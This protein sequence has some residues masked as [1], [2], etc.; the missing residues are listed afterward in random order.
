MSRFHV[1]GVGGPGMSAIAIVLVQMGHV[2]SG[3]DIRESPVLDSLRALGVHINI[4]HDTSVV[5]GC[6]AVTA[7]SAI[8]SDNIELESA[9]QHKIKVLTR[10]Q[11]LADICSKK[12]SIGVA[13][14]HGKTTTAAM[15]MLMLMDADMHPSFIIGGDVADV[16]TGARWSTGPM[17]VVEADESDGTHRQLPLAGTILTNIDIDHLDHFGNLEGILAGFDGYLTG[18]SGPKV[19]CSDDVRC[20]QLA[21]KHQVITYGIISDAQ[22]KAVRINFEHGACEFDVDRRDDDGSEYHT[23]GRVVVPLRGEHNVLNALAALTMAMAL[24]VSFDS[25]VRTLGNFGG[26]AR[27]FDHRGIDAGVTFVDDYAHLPAEI[28]AVLIGARDTS[29]SWKRI[30]AVFQPN[31]YN[32]MA[33]LSPAYADSFI[34]A[35]VV[36]IT[37]IYPSGTTP[38]PG[39]TGKLVV[40]AVLESHPRAHVVWLPHR[41][42][43]V[44]YLTAELRQG[45]LCIS[46]GCGDITNL[47]AEVIARRTQLR[48]ADQT[49]TLAR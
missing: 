38:I 41:A 9:R 16:D 33:V 7:S 32:R 19:L 49:K 10:A 25:A 23:L 43:L 36:V 8:P 4:G 24:G 46:M 11:M 12:S 13:G 42:Q 37:D 2:V 35:D 34:A 20:A 17:L 21:R 22:V 28:S 47:P 5:L 30:V 27:R 40:N 39:V 45:D 15:L 18:I 44:D 14:T 1:V 31:R 48:D 29:D 26:V 6:D 3:S